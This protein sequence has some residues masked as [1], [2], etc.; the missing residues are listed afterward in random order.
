MDFLSSFR[1]NPDGFTQLLKLGER[2]GVFLPLNYNML[3]ELTHFLTYIIRLYTFSNFFRNSHFLSL[4]IKTYTKTVIWTHKKYIFN[5]FLISLKFYV[6][7]AH[8][9]P[10]KKYFYI[11]TKKINH[12]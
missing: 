11:W 3:L 9:T 6:L 4:R 1:L 2:K 7:Y 5:Q 8:F 10:S 12:F